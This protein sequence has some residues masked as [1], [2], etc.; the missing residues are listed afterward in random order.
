MP[1]K[2]KDWETQL[3]ETAQ[4]IINREPFKY[5]MNEDAVYQQY[6]NAYDEQGKK[7]MEDT[8][9]QASALT[10]GYASSY[11]TTAGQQ[12]YNEYMKGL[13]DITPDLYDMAFQKYQNEGTALKERYNMLA[14]M[15]GGDTETTEDESEFIV[16]QE[17]DDIAMGFETEE[18]L[19]AW[20]NEAVANEDIT[21]EQ[22]E[23]YL[24]KFGNLSNYN[25]LTM[26]SKIKEKARKI[27][28]DKKNQADLEQYLNQQEEYG[29][30]SSDQ[31][32]AILAEYSILDKVNYI[33]RTWTTKNGGN[34]N[35]WG[36]NRDAKVIDQYGTEYKI[37]ELIDLI[38]E[39]ENWDKKETKE[40]LKELQKSLG[41]N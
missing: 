35:W 19:G 11:A 28:E 5:D 40:W 9:G 24:D 12:A 2:E 37:A 23:K 10:G 41:L 29:Y 8:I 34:G 20:I 6:K 32:Q 31:K 18:E 39:Q 38:M 14:G 4:E 33:K 16:N 21:P 15:V 36:L 17:I 25:D 7:A 26:Y 30:I 13:N 3:K 22:A 27:S 1:N